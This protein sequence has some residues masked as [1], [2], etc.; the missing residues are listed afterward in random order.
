MWQDHQSSP[1]RTLHPCG[2]HSHRQF[3]SHHDFVCFL[4]THRFWV[5]LVSHR[6]FL[7]L[8]EL[9][10]THALQFRVL[11]I[12]VHLHALPICLLIVF[13]H[14]NFPGFYPCDFLLWIC[15][16]CGWNLSSRVE[17]WALHCCSSHIVQGTVNSFPAWSV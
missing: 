10:N 8:H 6:H 3:H 2:L 16:W 7:P 13:T 4:L 14:R 9:M 15:E 12:V 1:T 17:L 11:P 5:V